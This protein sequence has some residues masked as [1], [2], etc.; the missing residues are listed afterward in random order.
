[1]VEEGINRAESL[2]D[3]DKLY[4]SGGNA[5]D[6]L[7]DDNVQE[8]P[9]GR[10][11]AVTAQIGDLEFEDEFSDPTVT[12]RNERQTAEHEVVTG[13]SAVREQG[14]EYV[15]Q[16]LG[17]SPPDIE[18]TGWVPESELDLVDDLVSSDHVGIRTA[19]WTGTAVPKTVDVNYSRVWHDI[20]GWIFETDFELIGVNKGMVPKEMQIDDAT[21]AQPADLG[22][23]EYERQ[24]DPSTTDINAE[25]YDTSEGGFDRHLDEGDTWDTTVETPDS[26]ALDDAVITM[27]IDDKEIDSMKVPAGSEPGGIDFPADL[28]RPGSNRVSFSTSKGKITNIEQ[29]ASFTQELTITLEEE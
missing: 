27:S 8:V 25:E 2:Q 23:P 6:P 1:M 11:G 24:G 29:G 14:I 19:R 5:G 12:V 18:I 15:V 3:P 9:D 16:A 7:G 13:H 17:R 22:F 4:G 21:E 28:P 26:G 20:H 10:V